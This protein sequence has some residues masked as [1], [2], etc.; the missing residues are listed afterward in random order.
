[1]TWFILRYR[2]WSPNFWHYAVLIVVIYMIITWFV[3][4]HA[5]AAEGLQTASL[6]EFNLE[7]DHDYMNYLDH[8]YHYDLKSNEERTDTRDGNC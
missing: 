8:K 4:I 5:D 3:D 6:S 1:M 7:R 2:V